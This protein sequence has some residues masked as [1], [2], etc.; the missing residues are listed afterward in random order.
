MTA[1]FVQAACVVG[2]CLLSCHS[3]ARPQISECDQPVS[4]SLWLL[5]GALVRQLRQSPDQPGYAQT[6]PQRGG[7]KNITGTDVWSLSPL[8][9][10]L[11]LFTNFLC[12]FSTH[13][14]S[15]FS[16]FSCLLL[17]VFPLF[18]LHFLFNICVSF[19]SLLYVYSPFDLLFSVFSYCF[20]LSLCLPPCS[21]KSI[22]SVTVRVLTLT[23]EQEKPLHV[24]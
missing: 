19:P 13:S 17:A 22:R 8:C 15:I 3:L 14:F 16:C 9:L 4:G 11:C 5:H 1:S 2:V 7:E 21:I 6:R 10:F 23:N 18:S 12:I 20:S 24:H